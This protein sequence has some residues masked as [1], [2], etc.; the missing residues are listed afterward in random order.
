MELRHL[1]YFVTI[2]EELSFTR[3]A[4]RLSVGQPPLSKQIRDLERELGGE[5]FL[6]LGRGIRLSAMGKAFFRDAKE[7]IALADRAAIN[8][9]QIARGELGAIQIGLDTAAGYQPFVPW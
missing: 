4:A 2:A 8:A 1:R 7:V 5:L 6:R 9:R 3:A